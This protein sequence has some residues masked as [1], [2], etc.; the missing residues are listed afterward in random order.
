M[1]LDILVPNE[2]NQPQK[3]KYLM[4]LFCVKYEKNVHIIWELS[5]GYQWGVGWEEWEKLNERCSYSKT[6][7]EAPECMGEGGDSRKQSWAV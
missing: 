3:D 4:I 1:E 7:Q 6:E 2:I 5:S